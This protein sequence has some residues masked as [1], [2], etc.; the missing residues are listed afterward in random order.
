MELTKEQSLK[1]NNVGKKYNLKLMLLHGSYAAGKQKVGSDI[2]IAI[3][4]KN[5]VDFDKYLKIYSELENIFG[6]SP[7]R[8]LDI[9]SLHRIDPLFCYQVAKCSQLLYGKIQDYN[10]FRA[11]AFRYYH[12]AKDLFELERLQVLKYQKYLNKKYA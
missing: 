10:E 11:Y 2:D 1:I 5:P 8:E 7:K 9:K 3:L 6:S 12:D 4:G